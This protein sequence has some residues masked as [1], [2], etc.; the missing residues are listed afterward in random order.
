M[1]SR[2]WCSS[3]WGGGGGDG[4]LAGADRDVI[5][6]ANPAQ[7][8]ATKE[9]VSESMKAAIF[10][11]GANGQKYKQLK[12]DLENNFTKGTEKY[13]TAVERAV[14]LLNTYTNPSVG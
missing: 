10:L 3:S 4:A 14:H 8:A 6:A 7:I 9:I 13:E 5:G 11:D 12:S 2:D 1:T